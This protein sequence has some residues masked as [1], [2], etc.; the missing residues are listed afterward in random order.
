MT[1]ATRR[2][3]RTR[4]RVF[5]GGAA[6][7]VLVALA[8]GGFA[9]SSGGDGHQATRAA[10]VV[11]PT[12]STAPTS[13]PTTTAAA[14]ATSAPPTTAAKAT[15]TTIRATPVKRSTNPIV[16][17][18]QQYD[19]TYE[20]TFTNTGSATSGN[21]TLELR[22]D[23]T[24]SSATMRAEFDGDLFGGGA[25]SVRS[26][27]G[28]VNLGDPSA[29]TTVQTAAFGPVSGHIDL[30]T[31]AL[32]LEAPDVPDAAV[33]SFAL[34]AKVN[35]VDR[36]FDAT[37]TVTFADRH[38]AAGTVTL[39]CPADGSGQRPSEVRTLCAA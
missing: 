19:G 26:L 4:R 22:V 10:R 12:G 20:G 13:S 9:L 28:T 1:R 39:R 31:Q 18:A 36:G 3:A 27:N 11:K 14:S 25:A 16:A 7:A 33:Q 37:F 17:L 15:T 5:I 8:V 35:T 30:V 34:T 6:I 2:R 32:I 23:P 21:A 29:V 24:T 38:T